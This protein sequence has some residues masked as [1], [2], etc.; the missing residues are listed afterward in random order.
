MENIQDHM[1]SDIERTKILYE[2]NKEKAI[3]FH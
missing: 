2:Y 1:S 3:N